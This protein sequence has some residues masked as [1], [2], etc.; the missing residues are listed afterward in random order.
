MKKM[1]E[2]TKPLTKYDKACFVLENT[3]DGDDLSDS[4]LWTVQEAVNG[5]LN[6][7]GMEEFEKLYVAV[8]DKNFVPYDKRPFHDIEHLTKDSEGYV[9]WKGIQVDHYDYDFWGKE[10]WQEKEKV[11]AQEL[12]GR[13]RLAE[14]HGIKPTTTSIV[15]K[16]EKTL[17]K[18]QKKEGNHEA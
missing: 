11:A 1:K 16:W 3:N 17:A 8:K 7:K 13:C 15:W 9:Y 12:A 4:E 6:E 14:E 10:G 5:H 18:I 2:N